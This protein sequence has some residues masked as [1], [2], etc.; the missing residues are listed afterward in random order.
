MRGR[1][2]ARAGHRGL[3]RRARSRRTG[4]RHSGCGR[5]PDGEGT[6][7]QPTRVPGGRAPRATLQNLLSFATLSAGRCR[8]GDTEQ[9]VRSKACSRVSAPTSGV[10]SASEQTRLCPAGRGIAIPC[11][12]RHGGHWWRSGRAALVAVVQ[13]AD[14]GQL[15]YLAHARRLDGSR[16]R[17]VFAHREVSS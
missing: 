15:D 16:L 5:D 1:P 8:G 12:H 2:A 14:F 11:R 4:R 13:A 3:R 7:G 17:R 9:K 10:W 6:P